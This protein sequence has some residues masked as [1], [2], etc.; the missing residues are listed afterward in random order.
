MAEEAWPPG[1]A[2]FVYAS[3]GPVKR[4]CLRRVPRNCASGM[5]KDVRFRP[6]EQVELCPARQKVEALMGDAEPVLALEVAVEL[7][8][9]RVQMQH[10]GGRIIELSLGEG[11]G[12]PVGGLLL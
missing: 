5:G 8:L 4:F 6:A 10:V 9:E 12:A 11:I 7:L 3:P 1:P 2:S